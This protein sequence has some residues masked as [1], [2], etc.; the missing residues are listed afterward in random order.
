MFRVYHLG[1]NNFSCMRDDLPPP[2]NA[3]LFWPVT[4]EQNSL[5]ESGADMFVHDGLL[6][7]AYEL[8]PGLPYAEIIE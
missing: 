1:H 4:E 8:E 7:I 6:V 5:I 3:D 2:Q